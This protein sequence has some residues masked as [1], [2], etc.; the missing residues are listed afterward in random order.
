MRHESLL[1]YSRE[2]AIGSHPEP[3]V[4]LYIIS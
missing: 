3:F 4:F 1:L 2:L